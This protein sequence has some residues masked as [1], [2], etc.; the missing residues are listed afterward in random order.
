MF[1]IE[2]KLKNGKRERVWIRQIRKVKTNKMNA[3]MKSLNERA[4]PT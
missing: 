2:I 4:I 1:K 3:G